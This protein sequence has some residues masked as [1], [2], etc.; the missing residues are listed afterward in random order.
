MVIRSGV[1]LGEPAMELTYAEVARRL[2]G[3]LEAAEN[4]GIRLVWYSPLPYCI[5]NPVLYGLG[6]K[7]CACVD[8]ILSVDPAGQVLPCSSFGDGIGS[9]LTSSFDRIYRSRAAAYWRR[10][11][12]VPPVCRDCPDV[13]V[14]GGGCPLYWD[15]AGSF[16]EIPRAAAPRPAREKRWQRR[17]RRGVSFGVPSPGSASGDGGDGPAAGVRGGA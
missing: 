11:E 4:A 3:L 2:P 5:F 1:A 9:L 14:C 15:A 17:R 6:A 7:S 10:K 13:D 16:D 8:G 12:F